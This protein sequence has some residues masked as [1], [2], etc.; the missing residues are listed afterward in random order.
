MLSVLKFFFYKEMFLLVFISK[1]GII[2]NMKSLLLVVCLCGGLLVTGCSK[3]ESGFAGAGVGSA[4]GAGIGYAIDG[5]VGGA[6]AGGLMG[7]IA[8]AAVGSATCKEDAYEP[9]SSNDLPRNVASDRSNFKQEIRKEH[10]EIEQEKI[11]FHKQELEKKR[12]DLERKR[13]E[14]EEKRLEKER[15][16]LEMQ[17]RGLKS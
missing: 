4:I 11:D 6:I 16:E 15:I 14:L 3:T 5:G 8:G 2:T 17:A 1:S 12:L 9:Y 13:L 10:Y 7:V